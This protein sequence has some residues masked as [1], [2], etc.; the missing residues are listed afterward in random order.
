MTDVI[1]ASDTVT[2]R[3][4]GK[5]D[6]RKRIIEAARTLIQETGDLGLS[7]RALAERANVSIATPYNLFGSKR[8]IILALLE[9]VKAFQ[10][11]FEAENAKGGIAKTFAA[12][13][14]I[15][16]YTREEPDL[17]RAIWTTILDTNGNAELRAELIPPQSD[18]FWYGL[19]EEA[20]RDGDIRPDIDLSALQEVMGGVFTGA[21]LKWIMGNCQVEDLDPT[22]GFGYALAFAGA[23]TEKSAAMLNTQLQ[24]FQ[25]QRRTPK[26]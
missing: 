21:M 18:Q 22:I 19:L 3:E 13:S 14:I 7:M 4:A 1:D 5:A 9:D 16:D 12:I 8:E 15:L 10:V 17:Y 2:K 6:R 23:A 26:R 11:R 20:V 24:D 25:H